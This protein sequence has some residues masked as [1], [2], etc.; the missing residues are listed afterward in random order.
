MTDGLQ[1]E[2]L[3]NLLQ[4]EWESLHEESMSAIERRVNLT[5]WGTAAYGALASAAAWLL[6][7]GTAFHP[8]TFWF[9]CTVMPTQALVLAALWAGE[10][11]RS[12]RA[13][14]YMSLVEA[15]TDALL[16]HFVVQE[17][18]SIVEWFHGDRERPFAT[19]SWESFL[20][21]PD[22]LRR[23]L[24]KTN[25]LEMPYYAIAGYLIAMALAPFCA[26]GWL[27]FSQWEQPYHPAAPLL[28]AASSCIYLLFLFRWLRTTSP[29]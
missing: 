4:A 8:V 13:G 22:R 18:T 2:H 14:L 20:R 5:V 16:R 7:E 10:A 21:Q 23:G 9:L 17:H 29:R 6:S 11:R 28:G 27:A 12:E 15:D 1:L 19:L 3:L 26:A 25:Q 24:W